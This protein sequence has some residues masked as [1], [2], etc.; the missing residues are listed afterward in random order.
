M[1]W[2]ENKYGEIEF[3][4][5][6]GFST[7]ADRAGQKRESLGIQRAVMS[8][9]TLI[10]RGERF[11]TVYADP[12]WQY[13][14]QATRAATDKHYSTM[15]LNEIANLPISDITTENAHLHIWTTNAFL[16][17]TKSIIE[18]WGFTYKSLFV[19]VKPQMGIGNYW[20]VSH[21]LLLLGVRG[22]LS[23]DDHS[24]KSWLEADRGKHSEKPD[25]IR[26]II[27]K[28]SP[29]PRIELFGR[30]TFPGWTTWGNQIE[31]SLF[32]SEII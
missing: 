11:S 6:P 3:N 15:S 10:I 14:N 22:S 23:F 8:L 25:K 18:A 26:E 24:Y 16:F 28:V 31:P 19:W 30:K 1:K 5:I 4:E 17:D 13:T 7:A 32:C 2:R 20:R 9:E 29:C 27:E 21:E 12:P